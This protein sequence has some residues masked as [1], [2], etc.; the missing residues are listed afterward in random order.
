MKVNSPHKMKVLSKIPSS[1]PPSP[2]TSIPSQGFVGSLTDYRHRKSLAKILHIPPQLP[3][4]QLPLFFLH[5]F[6]QFRL[7]TTNP[8]PRSSQHNR[9]FRLYLAIPPNLSIIIKTYP[10]LASSTISCHTHYNG[11]RGRQ[12]RRRFRVFFGVQG[13]GVECEIDLGR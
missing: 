8:N 3:T 12:W 10:R 2:L 5:H 13:G 11:I 6:L 7:E 9:I 4:L 1:P